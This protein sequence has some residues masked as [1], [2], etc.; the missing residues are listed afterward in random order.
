[1]SI[2]LCVLPGIQI[3]PGRFDHAAALLNRIVNGHVS[4]PG[5]HLPPVIAPFRTAADP[6]RAK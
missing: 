6:T 1:M 3:N 4:Q 2:C 5:K